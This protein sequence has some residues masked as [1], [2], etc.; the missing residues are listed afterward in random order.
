MMGGPPD[1]VVVSL[2]PVANPANTV[3]NFTAVPAPGAGQAFRVWLFG[4]VLTG[5]GENP[6]TDYVELALNTAATISN[7]IYANT[8]AGGPV[9]IPGGVRLPE[10]MSLNGYVRGSG[11][12]IPITVAMTIGYTIELV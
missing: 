2:F 6:S 8:M 1:L 4:G 12:G 9:A 5:L 11:P 3:V 10:N 7:R